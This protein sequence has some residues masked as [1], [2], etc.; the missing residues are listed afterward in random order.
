MFIYNRWTSSCNRKVL[1]SII[2]LFRLNSLSSISISY[3]YVRGTIC[4][5]WTISLD[6][7]LRSWWLCI[8]IRNIASSSSWI[9]RMYKLKWILNRL[10]SRIIINIKMVK[11]IIINI[12]MLNIIIINN[13]MANIII[14]NNKMVNIIIIDNKVVNIIIIN[15]I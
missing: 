11:M 6:S 4:R 7:C 8:S 10:N 13:K 9:W 1:I 5:G 14:I 12:K 3:C 15:R 2:I